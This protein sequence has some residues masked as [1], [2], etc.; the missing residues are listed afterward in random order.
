MSKTSYS[1]IDDDIDSILLPS[2]FSEIDISDSSDSEEE[3]DREEIENDDREE[4]EE[5]EEEENDDDDEEEEDDREEIENDDSE[6][7]EDDREE[8]GADIENNSGEEEE[9]DDS[10]EE[11]EDIENDSEEEEDDREEMSIFIDSEEEAVVSDSS[12]EESDSS[13]SED[14]EEYKEEEPISQDEGIYGFMDDVGDSVTN[15]SDESEDSSDY[16]EECEMNCKCDNCSRISSEHKGFLGALRDAVLS[17]V[18]TCYKQKQK[19]QPNRSHV[20]TSYQRPLYFRD[21]LPK[22][23]ED[24]M[25]IS[26]HKLYNSSDSESGSIRRKNRFNRRMTSDVLDR[27]TSRKSVYANTDT[28]EDEDVPLE[29]VELGDISTLINYTHS[30]TTITPSFIKCVCISPNTF[31]V[32][33]IKN[34]SSFAKDELPRELFVNIVDGDRLPTCHNCKL[35]P[36]SSYNHRYCRRCYPKLQVCTNRNCR[37]KTHKQSGLCCKCFKTNAYNHPSISDRSRF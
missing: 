10:E 11:E 2:S 14:E 33:S 31:K 20:P 28:E 15:Y 13:E 22:K 35:N 26:T 7:D 17:H 3:E 6:E 29:S 18:E 27:L 4:E 23:I 25:N 30:G 16:V 34:G 5:E 36:T 19:H 12:D 37:N 9:D 8:E 21:I 32:V 24:A 1:N